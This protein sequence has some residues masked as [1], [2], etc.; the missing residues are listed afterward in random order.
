MVDARAVVDTIGDETGSVSLNVV[1]AA[2]ESKLTP[3]EFIKIF[4]GLG[5]VYMTRAA[6]DA[7]SRNW[8][9]EVIIYA[10]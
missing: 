9:Y 7:G 3:P 5:G 2:A 10:K 8:N 4:G 6:W 1:E